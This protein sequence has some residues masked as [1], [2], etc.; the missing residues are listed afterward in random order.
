VDRYKIV[1][2]VS[3]PQEPNAFG[4]LLKIQ[5]AQGWKYL[6]FT[7]LGVVFENMALPSAEQTYRQ[8]NTEHKKMKRP[9][10]G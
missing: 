4:Q 8:K 10:W 9:Y 6:N 5:L 1:E 2:L 7:P 3:F